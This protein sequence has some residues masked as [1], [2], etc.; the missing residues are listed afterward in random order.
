MLG[1]KKCYYRV[2]ME[3]MRKTFNLQ[4]LESVVARVLLQME[5]TR[6]SERAVV[7][8]FEGDLGAG[9]TTFVKELAKQ[10]G[11]VE[12]VTSPTFVVMRHYETDHHLY[13]EMIHI[14]AYR[15]E[16]ELESSPLHLNQYVVKP[17]LIVCIEWP[18]RLP[19]FMSSNPHFTI[20]LRVVSDEERELVLTK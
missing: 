7:L 18:S 9:K 1:S 4:S 5:N 11:I 8:A 16:S 13:K 15:F 2:I 6:D 3:L 20:V 19:E 12:T 14:D 17:D 10:I